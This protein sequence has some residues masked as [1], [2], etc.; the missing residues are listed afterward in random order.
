MT[1][2]GVPL[3][4][5]VYAYIVYE[6]TPSL[7]LMLYIGYPGAVLTMSAATVVEGHP[8]PAPAV[9]VR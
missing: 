2:V 3:P 9:A 6:L 1:A 4:R 8:V 7:P 5:Y